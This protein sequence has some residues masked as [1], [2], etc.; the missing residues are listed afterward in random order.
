MLLITYILWIALVLLL[1]RFMPRSGA[2]WIIL[3]AGFLLLPPA[4][5][6]APGDRSIF[7]Y[8]IVGGALPSDI[9]ITKAW[10][11]PVAALI[12]SMLFERPRWQAFRLGLRDLP[13]LLF[14][15]WPIL[16][17]SF[18]GP[19]APSGVISTCYLLGVWGI[20]CLLGRL[21][22][23]SSEDV[24]EFAGVLAVATIATLP[25]A[26]VETVSSF[27]FQSLV[28]SPH[29]FMF[30]GI[31]RYVGYRPQLM[32]E[33]G[34]QYGVW[35]AS[36]SLAA[37]WRW[38]LTRYEGRVNQ[39]WLC[40]AALLLFQTFASQSVGAIMLLSAAVALLVARRASRFLFGV[41]PFALAL[42][43]MIGALH[44]SGIV[45]LRSLAKDTAVGRASLN[46][47]REAGRQSFAWR[48][49][50]D[51][52]TTALIQKSLA[53]GAHEWDWFRPAGTRPWGLPL[54][55]LGQFGILGLGAIAFAFV[56]GLLRLL[57][58]ARRENEAATLCVLLL[59]V[60]ALD[61][62][63][64]SFLFYPAIVVIGAGLARSSSRPLGEPAAS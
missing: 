42:T 34:N 3:I 5:Y 6:A 53:A 61:A 37:I 20:P 19:T 41:M 23:R 44:V 48:I 24:R 9:L 58:V 11:A 17:L 8:W 31:E 51:L 33:N 49:S 16:R 7:P 15:I 38:R 18:T 29:P 47:L 22:L 30:D 35:C 55:I 26:L 52:K 59:L 54:L 10:A 25:F 21:H 62:L 40:I 39:R 64:N 14:C 36:A 32:F 1:Y 57:G 2:I 45:P 27:R 46:L 63:L 12:A 28:A 43:A 50:Q 60:S 4:L 13:I 56:A